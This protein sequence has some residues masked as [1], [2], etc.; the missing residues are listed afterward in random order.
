V[1]AERRNGTRAHSARSGEY[2][3]AL[4]PGGALGW[5][6]PH[7]PRW[8]RPPDRPQGAL[9]NATLL[10]FDTATEQM[11]VGLA[12]ADRSW[13]H[14]GAGGAQASAGLLPAILGLLGNARVC[15]HDLDAIAFGR[16]PGAFTG[17]RTACSV[18][19]G[20][21]LGA[22]KPVL[23]IDT[24]QAIA[25]DAR[26]DAGAMQ[27]WAVLD[28]RMGQ[29]YAAHYH[30]EQGQWSRPTGP[31]LADPDTLNRIWQTQPPMHVAGNA[32]T[33]FAGRLDGGGAVRHPQ[34]KPS[35]AALVNLACAQWARNGA[36]DAADALP[37]YVRDQ[38]AQTTLERARHAASGAT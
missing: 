35:A 22:R 29:I 23:A 9:V 6:V 3:S 16:G 19:Q 25:E 30:Y 28:A 34:A 12:R 20:L 36:V 32:L 5:Q 15:I 1:P 7:E 38:V 21:A 10:A 13:L 18:V 26:Q 8:V 4:H 33:A 11:H 27:V 31:M 37:L 17:L 14:E 24:L 2:D